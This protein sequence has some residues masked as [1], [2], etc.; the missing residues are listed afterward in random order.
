MPPTTFGTPTLWVD[1]HPSAHFRPQSPQDLYLVK[2]VFPMGSTKALTLKEMTSH[3]FARCQTE[4]SRL[5]K[6]AGFHVRENPSEVIEG[7][8]MDMFERLD[9]PDEPSDKDAKVNQT[10]AQIG[11]GIG[12]PLAPSFLEVMGERWLR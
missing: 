2:P 4:S 1:V 8:V 9:K 10:L 11:L 7:A 5:A 12:A 3:R 6:V